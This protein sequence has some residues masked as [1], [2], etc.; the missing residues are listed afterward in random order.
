MSTTIWV[1]LVVLWINRLMLVVCLAVELFALVNCLSQRAEAF[2]IVGRV[3][4]LGWI[5]LLMLSLVL[6]LLVGPVS[7]LG[8]IAVTV[9]LF[10][11]LDVRRGLKD[12]VEGGPGSW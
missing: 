2:P 1:Y 10:Y 6:T 11:V 8:Y 9:A 5:A 3:P 12:A 7:L 4:K